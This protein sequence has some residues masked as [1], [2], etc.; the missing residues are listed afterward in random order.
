MLASEENDEKIS[1]SAIECLR[2]VN[3]CPTLCY[4]RK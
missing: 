1:T 4:N 3:L 2:K